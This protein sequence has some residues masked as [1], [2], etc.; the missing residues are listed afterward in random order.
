[1]FFT[2]AKLCKF[3]NLSNI[4]VKSLKL[5]PTIDQTGT[6]DYRTGKFISES[7]KPLTKIEFII[8]NTQGFSLV[9]K[10]HQNCHLCM[11]YMWPCCK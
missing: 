10:E 3:D 8:N 1:M 5:Q 11:I 9:L 7:L 2:S 6:Y 4:N